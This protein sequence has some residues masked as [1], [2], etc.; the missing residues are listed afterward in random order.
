MVDIGETIP[1]FYGRY[2]YNLDD[3]GRAAIPA[4]IREIIQLR[5]MKTLM[6]RLFE[7]PNARFI[8]AYPANYFR[9]KILP[10]ASQF[11]EESEEGIYHK[12]AI[13]ASC[14]QLRLDNQGRINLP[15]EFLEA[16]QIQKEIRYIGM[17]DFFDMWNPESNDKFVA[18]LGQRAEGKGQRVESREHGAE[19]GVQS[20]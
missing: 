3:K 17:G 19:S 11:D 14:Q 12:Q 15:A 9:D 7:K 20:A 4:K 18:T 1:K 5:D 6:L 16:A 8:R 10:M 13:L 2:H